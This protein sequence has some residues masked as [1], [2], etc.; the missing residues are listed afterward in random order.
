MR[1]SVEWQ[2]GSPNRLVPGWQQDAIAPEIVEPQRVA[3]DFGKQA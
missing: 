2:K 1:P 3:P